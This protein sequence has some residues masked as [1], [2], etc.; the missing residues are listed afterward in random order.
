M[1]CLSTLQ[2][3]C[4]VQPDTSTSLLSAGVCVLKKN[5]SLPLH[6]R[7]TESVMHGLVVLETNMRSKSVEEK[8]SVHMHVPSKGRGHDCLHSTRDDTK[9]GKKILFI[10]NRDEK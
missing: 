5:Y 3:W 6:P 7:H 1:H 9:Q 2:D 10:F 8:T 4:T